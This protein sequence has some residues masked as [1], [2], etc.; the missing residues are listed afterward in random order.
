MS[1]MDHFYDS[2]M[3]LKCPIHRNYR[4]KSKRYNLK[5]PFVFHQRK[6]V[7]EVGTVFYHLPPAVDSIMTF[8]CILEDQVDP[9]VYSITKPGATAV[10]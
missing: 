6:Q 1:H 10:Y 4:K 7:I 9:N 2:L 8:L 5:T 3:V